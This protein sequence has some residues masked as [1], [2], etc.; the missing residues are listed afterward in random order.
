MEF[1]FSV[2]FPPGKSKSPKWYQRNPIEFYEMHWK[3]EE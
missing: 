2:D 3:K 1:P